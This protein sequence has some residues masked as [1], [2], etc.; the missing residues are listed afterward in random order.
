VEAIHSSGTS[1]LS[2]V[3]EKGILHSHH[4]ENLK[5]LTG[6]TL[7]FY[8]CN[9]QMFAYYKKWC[10]VTFVFYFLPRIL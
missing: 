2:R 1:D 9:T 4:R 10:K 7:Y 3:P 6:K 5:S 8:H